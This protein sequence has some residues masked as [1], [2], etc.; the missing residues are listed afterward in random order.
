MTKT[1]LIFILYLICLGQVVF[2]TYVPILQFWDEFLTILFLGIIITHIIR[3]DF[4]IE[5]RYY[6]MLILIVLLAIIGL[7]GNLKAQI[8]TGIFPILNDMGNCFK[9]YIAYIG[10]NIYFTNHNIGQNTNILNKCTKFTY[11]LVI[12]MFFFACLNLIMDFGMRDEYRFGIPSFRFIVGGPGIFSSL[13][14]IILV[15]MTIELNNDKENS[16][17]KFFIILALIV[18]ASTLRIRIMVH[19]VFYIYICYHVIYKRRTKFNTFSVLLALILI[20]IMTISQ[21]H[22]YMDEGTTAR[23]NLIYWGYKTAENYF[24]IGAGFATYGT[25]A[26]AK[27]YSHLYEWYGFEN[28][29]GLSSD[30]PV[31]AKDNYW[32]A[33]MGEFGFLGVIVMIVLIFMLFSDIYKIAGNNLYKKA[34]AYFVC[35]TQVFQS[36]GS[37]VFFH[38][39]TV[40]L[41]IIISFVML[42]KENCCYQIS[43]KKN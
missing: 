18:W 41:M 11:F 21:I 31:F 30:D 3:S 15:I 1:T 32:P 35:F 28:V 27:Y 13:F 2:Q 23:Y 43:Q 34:I 7:I 39:T 40:N 24:P 25:D 29:F 16:R 19:M 36:I 20:Y 6:K 17:T 14:Y 26:A 42:S 38:F 22:T 33:V 9:V 5:R 4:K 12:V 10:A 37:P 8:Q